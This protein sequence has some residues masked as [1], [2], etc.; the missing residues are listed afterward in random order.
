MLIALEVAHAL[1]LIRPMWATH[2]GDCAESGALQ[3]YMR[4]RTVRTAQHTYETRSGLQR[5]FNRIVAAYV[6]ECLLCQSD[7]TPGWLYGSSP[8]LRTL[9][10][11]S[12]NPEAYRALASLATNTDIFVTVVVLR[13]A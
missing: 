1:Q 2:I 11:Q 9:E 10:V 13:L 4:H 8:K 7:L 12:C 3:A 5:L 6:G